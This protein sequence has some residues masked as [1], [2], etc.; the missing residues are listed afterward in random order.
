M[1]EQL[2]LGWA[3]A[4]A[5]ASPNTDPKLRQGA[6]YPVLANHRNHV[7]LRVQG[8]RVTVRPILTTWAPS[9]VSAR[10]PATD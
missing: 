3:R 1:E 8:K 9:T 4:W 2:E 10:G 5:V 7:A 6:W